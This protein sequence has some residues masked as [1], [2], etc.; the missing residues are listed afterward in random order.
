MNTQLPKGEKWMARED[1]VPKT[2]LPEHMVEY[3]LENLPG[4][5][6]CCALEEGLPL[7]YVGD[8]FLQILGWTRNELQEQ[9]DNRYMNLV[10]PADWDLLQVYVEKIQKTAEL[11][12]DTAAAGGDGDSAESL[13]EESKAADQVHAEQQSIVYRMKGK[14]GYRWVKDAGRIVG[15]EN[16]DKEQQPKVIVQGMITDITAYAREKSD[17]ERQLEVAL[18]TAEL[19]NEVIS[20]LESMYQVICVI[21]LLKEEYTVIS[22]GLDEFDGMKLAGR[23]GSLM[24]MRRTMMERTIDPESQ[25]ELR[26]FLDFGKVAR[27]LNETSFVSGEIKSAK[28]QW[29]NMN[30]MAK[31]RAR[32]GNVVQILMAVRDVS[33]TKMQEIEYQETL[34][35]AL[36][37]A[38]DDS[39]FREMILRDINRRLRSAVNGM[40]GIAK[41]LEKY[42]D[43]IQ[44]QMPYRERLGI[45][46]QQLAEL[47]EDEFGEAPVARRVGDDKKEKEILEEAI[48][49]KNAAGLF[50]KDTEPSEGEEKD[51]AEGPGQDETKAPAA[52]M[53]ALLAEDNEL[54]QEIGKFLLEEVGFEVVDIA[55]N[56]SRAVELFCQSEPGTYDFIFMDVQMPILDGLEAT[57][58]IRGSKRKDSRKVR[59]LA[60]TANTYPEDIQSC[61][62]AGMNGHLSKP[63]SMNRLQELLK[64]TM[65]TTA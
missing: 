5:Y 40:D 44:K 7:L 2:G 61:L 38:A 34:L 64:E 36:R 56:G 27:K 17:R 13:N 22:G 46:V 11:S 48:E 49:H 37:K 32:N 41:M 12:L 23:T 25:D 43:D 15:L 33:E 45:A 53:K 63:L 59:I 65:E 10:H 9:F 62:D 51:T 58:Q 19:H 8:G 26:R 18:T 47:V 55:E 4:G 6:H 30:M 16:S 57:R 60:M 1:I 21:D 29:L 14:N 52:G 28:G 20:S 35:R 31:K 42:K 54:S 3:M 39:S 24:K 50:K